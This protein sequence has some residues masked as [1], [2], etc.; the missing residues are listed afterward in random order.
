MDSVYAMGYKLAQIA[1]VKFWFHIL[2]IATKLA[3][4]LEF[5]IFCQHGNTFQRKKV[6]SC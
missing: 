3:F 1:K 6:A 2:K 5:P 4:S